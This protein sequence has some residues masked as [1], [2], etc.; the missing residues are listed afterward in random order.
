[1][2]EEAEILYG[3]KVIPG[4]L[5]DSLMSNYPSSASINL[6]SQLREDNEVYLGSYTYQSANISDM[7]N[8]GPQST[9]MTIQIVESGSVVFTQ[10][11]GDRYYSVISL[12]DPELNANRPFVNTSTG[13][14]NLSEIGSAE[15]VLGNRDI[16]NDRYCPFNIERVGTTVKYY[17][18]DKLIYTSLASSSEN[19]MPAVF[20]S[21]ADAVSITTSHAQTESVWGHMHGQVFKKPQTDFF[22]KVGTTGSSNGA[23]NSNFLYLQTSV[24]EGFSIKIDGVEA[25][26]MGLEDNGTLNAGEVSVFPRQGLIRCS[27]AD[28]GKTVTVSIPCAYRS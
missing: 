3:F 6:G 23:F 20:T 17:L 16:I 15:V 26:V 25:T 12:F 8:E 1:M 24:R 5:F 10:P 19:L 11:A 2:L 28:A 13:N 22:V 21:F 7:M 27:S 9:P 14:V 18:R 4:K